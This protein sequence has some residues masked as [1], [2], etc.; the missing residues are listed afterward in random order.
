[1]SI[2]EKIIQVKREEVENKREYF[3]LLKRDFAVVRVKNNGTFYN[4]LEKKGLSIVAEYKRSSPSS[5][6]ISQK[7]SPAQQARHYQTGGA[8]AVSVLTDRN[9]FNGSESDLLTIKSSVSLP[10]LRKDFII[11][12]GQLY[13]SFFLGSD[14]VL[15]ISKI[16]EYEQLRYFLDI[17]KESG[18]DA[19]VEVRSLKD[20]NKALKAGARI[21]GINNR[22]LETFRID[23]NLDLTLKNE[24][25][26]GILTVSESG[27]SEKSHILAIKRK[28]YDGV[29]IGTSLMRSSDPAGYLLHLSNREE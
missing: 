7:K 6:V 13:E 10:V 4:A 12:E 20:L 28:G 22:D 11:D 27:V 29:L 8:S 14:A 3:A 25:P 26:A 17:V 5:G 15:L 18:M 24:V 1:V 16:L 2:L 19:L 21:I 23:M 9:F